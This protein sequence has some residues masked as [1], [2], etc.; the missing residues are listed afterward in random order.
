[1]NFEKNSKKQNEN[2]IQNKNKNKKKE[3]QE[4]DNSIRVYDDNAYMLGEEDSENN[5]L[6]NL[7]NNEKNKENDIQFQSS[8]RKN[9]IED[10]Y[11][12]INKE[13][14]QEINISNNKDKA[15]TISG[16]NDEENRQKE[17]MVVKGQGEE[18]GQEGGEDDNIPLVTLKYISVCQCCKIPFDNIGH[19][20]Y[21]FKCGH[22]FCKKC[23]EEQFTGKEGI[24]CPIDG[25]IAKS[26]KQLKVLNNLV[27]DKKIF[28][29]III[30]REIILMIN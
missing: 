7:N 29:Q 24:K 6:N 18:E 23:I 27:T 8:E 16:D 30:K 4:E 21:L 11:D 9:E 10:V 19:L 20:P 28:S 3:E 12:I 13:V 14:N 5:S 15:L 1:M 26:I 22:F 17:S 25:P 2:D